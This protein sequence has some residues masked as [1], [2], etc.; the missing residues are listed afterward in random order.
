MGKILFEI[1]LSALYP[2]SIHKNVYSQR[3]FAWEIAKCC[4]SGY[5]FFHKYEN[6]GFWRNKKV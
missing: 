1:K 2:L 3:V 5:D 4:S 6:S